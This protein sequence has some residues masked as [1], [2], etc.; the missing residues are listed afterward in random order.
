MS[1]KLENKRDSPKIQTYAHTHTHTH[2]RAFLKSGHSLQLIR[3][4]I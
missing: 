2:A 3:T 1:H 4:V